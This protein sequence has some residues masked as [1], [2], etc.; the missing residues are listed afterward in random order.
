MDAM[1]QLQRL[2]GTDIGVNADLIERVESTPDTVLT[3]IDGTKYIVA[4]AAEE[5]VARIIEF[6]AR[7][8]AAAEEFSGSIGEQ[9]A[10]Q[11]I[12]L[13]LVGSGG[14]PAEAALGVAE[15]SSSDAAVTTEA[16]HSPEGV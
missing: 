3:L 9:P 15:P 4:E 1:I 7:I 16:A 5:V 11:S 6:R 12:P 8:L 10:G 13:R 2:N 14:A